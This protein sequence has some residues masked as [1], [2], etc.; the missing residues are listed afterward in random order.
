MAQERYFEDVQVGDV[1]RSA[2]S[3]RMEAADIAAFA[4]RFDPHPAHL[5]EEGARSTMFG[6]MCASGWHT[7][8]VTNSLLFATL[9]IAGGGAGSG[10]EKFRWLR[11][12]Y[13]GDE[14]RVEVEVL[15]ARPSRSRPDAGVVSYRCATLNQADEPVQEF[16]CT[17]LMPRREGATHG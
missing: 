3:V 5:S 16:S 2:R 12:V 17:V 11:P 14:L 15:A 6:R 13:P 9:R 10:I 8:A 7:A 1:F 4:R